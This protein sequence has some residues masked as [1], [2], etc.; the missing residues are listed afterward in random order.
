MFKSGLITAAMMMA[1]AQTALA[2]QPPPSAGSQLQQIPAPPAPER[3]APNI[4]VVRPDESVPATEPGARVQVNALRVTGNTLF[5]QD[6][7]IDAAGVR[8]GSELTLAELRAAAARMSA[9]Y[10]ARGYFLAQAYLPAQDIINGEVTI[11]VVEGRYGTTQIRNATNLSDRAARNVLSGLRP[12]DPVAAAPLE[13]RL[14]LLSDIPGV[15]VRS[16]LAPG[17]AVGTSDLIVDLAPGPRVSGSIEADNAGNR[18]TGEYRAGGTINLNNPTGLGDLASLRVL[19]ST[20]GLAYG[21]AAYQVPLGDATIGAAY[22]HLR[23]QLGREF[24]DLEADGT[25]N[26]FSVFGSYPLIRSRN[27]NL[28]A[29]AGL[30]LRMLE[31]RI[32]LVSAQS[33]KTSHV[34]TL[35]LTG[36]THDSFGGDGRNF[37]SVSWTLGKLFIDSPVERA[38]DAATART[39]G[40]FSRVQVS[41]ARLQTVTGPL[42]VYAAVRGQLAFDNLDSSE[43]MELGGANAVR[44]YPEGEA[45]GDQGYIATL[46]ARLMLTGL[47]STLPGRLQLFGFVDVGEVEFSRN[48]WFAGSN[49]ARRSAVGAGLTWFA[50]DDLILR[51]T[52]ATRLGDEPVTSGP[53]RAGRFWVHFAKLF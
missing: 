32:G 43:K 31:D 8:P 42:S 37:F 20:G 34:L 45:Y 22:T 52:Y 12:G 41:A 23:Y 48:P 53:D 33:D 51:A 25:A 27:A 26:I 44:S 28:Y 35:G 3:G 6:E 15:E 38:I 46:E 7:L 4:N 47:E 5:S 13:R 10:N 24:S 17:A 9:F 36:D 29:L 21:R 18:F 40:T 30:D 2:Q 14:L 19:A 11:A 49:H 50:P 16:T 1:T 39:A